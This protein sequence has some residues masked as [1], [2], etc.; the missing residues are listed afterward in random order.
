MSMKP[1][2]TGNMIWRPTMELRWLISTKKMDDGGLF[3]KPY[4]RIEYVLQQLWFRPGN[5]E[6][7]I[8]REWRNV[9]QVSE[10]E[11][12]LKANEDAAK[13]TDHE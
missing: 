9:P 12:S 10:Y 4:N 6:T 3:A 5:A 11:L 13:E 1:I 7:G 2:E 8:E